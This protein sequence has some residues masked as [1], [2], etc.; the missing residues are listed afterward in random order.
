MDRPHSRFLRY[1]LSLSAK[2][3]DSWIFI[4][5]NS[6]SHYGFFEIEFVMIN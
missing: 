4:V 1:A 5:L 6:G 3:I 2:I